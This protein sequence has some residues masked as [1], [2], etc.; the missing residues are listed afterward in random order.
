MITSAIKRVVFVSGRIPYVIVRDLGC[1]ITVLNVHPP[2]D[3]EGELS[4]G[5]RACI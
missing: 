3:V 4:C 1:D 2:T 5:A